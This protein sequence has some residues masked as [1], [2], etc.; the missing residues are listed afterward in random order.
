MLTLPTAVLRATFEQ[1]RA[2]GDGKR[3][4]VAYWCAETGAP[5]VLTGVVHPTH[6]AAGGGYVVNDTWVMEFFR[7]LHHDQKTVRA[8]V[9]T[10][11]RGASHSWIDDAYALIPAQGFLSLVVPDFGL[12]PFGL[13]GTH[14]VEMTCDGE[15]AERDPQEVFGHG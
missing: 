3:E 4:C 15:W 7:A 1:F 9:H 8:Q 2:C 12:G 13:G 6:T 5:D 11:P 10:H 14:L